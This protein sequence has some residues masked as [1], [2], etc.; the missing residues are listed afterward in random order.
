[1]KSFFITFRAITLAQRAERAC[2]QMG[3]RCSIRRTPRWMAERGCGYGLEV[4]AAGLEIPLDILSRA[5][6]RHRKCY[7]LHTD[8]TVEEVSNAVP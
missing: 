8:G 5:G 1:M 3:L 4:Q 7:L 6:I 2:S